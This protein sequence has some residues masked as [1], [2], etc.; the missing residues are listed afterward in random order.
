MTYIHVKYRTC[1]THVY[2]ST[3][4]PVP[5]Y[6]YLFILRVISRTSQ[7]LSDLIHVQWY[8]EIGT[9]TYTPTCICRQCVIRNRTCV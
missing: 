5:V 2:T 6:I 9:Y 3:P 8:N 7:C 4:V 1:G